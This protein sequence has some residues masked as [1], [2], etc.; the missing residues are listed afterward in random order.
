ME[1]YGVDKKNP[2]NIIDPI[3]EVEVGRIKAETEKI[4]AEKLKTDLEIKELEKKFNTPWFKRN[5]F[6][7]V[8]VAGLV[9]IPLIWF[10]VKDIAI[11]LYNK[12]NINCI[13]SVNFQLDC[14]MQ[15]R[16]LLI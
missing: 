2:K 8:I 5:A 11:P 14:C 3:K 16:P 12:D 15:V 1:S 10:Y 7:Q 4:Q 6:F 9:A 13:K